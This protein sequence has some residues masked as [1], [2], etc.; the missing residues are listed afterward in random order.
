MD[1]KWIPSLVLAFLSTTLTFV[2]DVRGSS[3]PISSDSLSKQ[4][5]ELSKSLL[6]EHIQYLKGNRPPLGYVTVDA[7]SFE[8]PITCTAEDFAK[9]ES[10]LTLPF[11]ERNHLSLIVFAH[12]QTRENRKF[13]RAQLINLLKSW[14]KKKYESLV[15]DLEQ[16]R[17]PQDASLEVANRGRLNFARQ[18]KLSGSAVEQRMNGLIQSSPSC[19]SKINLAFSDHV[20]RRVTQENAKALLTKLRESK[21][22]LPAQESDY[23]AVQKDLSLSDGWNHSFSWT[24]QKDHSGKETK[25]IK[26]EGASH[27]DPNDDLF[28]EY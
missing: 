27:S 17:D 28:F 11:L 26:S 9:I 7:V 24:I 15:R 12:Q 2:K 21:N 25:G 16:N 3:T 13:Y 20:R 5:E 8:K 18:L 23:Q 6:P 19:L 4:L 22:R 14:K 10:L 1:I